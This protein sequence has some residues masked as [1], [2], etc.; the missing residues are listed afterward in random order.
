MNAS[1]LDALMF[2]SGFPVQVFQSIESAW[3]PAFILIPSCCI[4][5]SELESSANNLNK[6]F[7]VCSDGVQE[8]LLSNT[9]VFIAAADV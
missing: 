3:M 7:V 5:K 2:Y 4:T 8:K 6:C 9:I 1:G